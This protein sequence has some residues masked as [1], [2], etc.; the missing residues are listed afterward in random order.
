MVKVVMFQNFK[1]SLHAEHNAEVFHEDKKICTIM[2]I[3]TQSPELISA[4]CVGL[5]IRKEFHSHFSPNQSEATP[6]CGS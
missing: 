5:Q 6:I 1:F 4:H 2:I 3:M